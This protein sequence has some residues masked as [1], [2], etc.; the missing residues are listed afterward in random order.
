V[1]EKLGLKPNKN[2][3]ECDA[4]AR[5]K[6]ERAL[7][8]DIARQR[9]EIL[10]EMASKLFEELPELAQRYI[11]LIRKISMKCRVRIPRHIKRRICKHCGTFLVPGVNCRVRLRT[12]RYPHITITCFN[13]K[14]QIRYPYKVNR[15]KKR[16]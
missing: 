12:N 7:I 4:M 1:Y 16:S 14:R 8:R 6:S 9:M 2:D 13:C 3:E 11:D 10:Y 15:V 5:R